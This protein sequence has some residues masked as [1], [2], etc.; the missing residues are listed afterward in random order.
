MRYIDFVK[1]VEENTKN[2]HS[3]FYSEYLRMLDI[4]SF[5]VTL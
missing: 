1:Y 4:H 2:I 5:Q 3:K